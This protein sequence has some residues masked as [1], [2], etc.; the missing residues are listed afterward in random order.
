[1]ADGLL[2]G[3][4]HCLLE[5]QATFLFTEMTDNFVLCPQNKWCISRAM[6]GGHALRLVVPLE[7]AVGEV[8]FHAI[9]AEGAPERRHLLALR[10][11]IGGDKGTT[12]NVAIVEMLPIV[13]DS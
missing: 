11:G 10:D 4:I 6:H 3:I 12:G 9:L 8:D 1:M 2:M 7:R 13:R 5:L